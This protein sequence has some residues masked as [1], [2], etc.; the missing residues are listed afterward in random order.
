LPGGIGQPTF[1]IDE[2]TN[3]INGY[4]YDA[5]GNLLDQTTCPSGSHQ[6]AY[7]GANRLTSV[8]GTAATY[9]YFG[10]LRIKKLLGSPSTVYIYSGNKPIAEYVNSSLSKEYIYFGSKLLATIAGTSAT[11]HHP[12]HLSNRAETNAT[13]AAIR[14]FGHFPYGETWY[15]TGTADKP[16]NPAQPNNIMASDDKKSNANQQFADG[17]F[18]ISPD[19]L[20]KLLKDCLKKHPK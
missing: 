8:N 11:Y 6:Y 2:T 17:T 5:A 19:D 13:G 9:S 4:C 7:D 12:D 16:F 14:T 3:R 20:S 10:A 15:E 18:K 1:T